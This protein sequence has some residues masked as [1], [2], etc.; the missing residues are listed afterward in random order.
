[1]PFN[2]PGGS[3]LQWHI[4]EVCLLGTTYQY[5]KMP[6]NAVQSVKLQYFE[7]VCTACV[8]TESG[9]NHRN[10]YINS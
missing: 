5:L 7:P 4:G 3:T 2:S 6:F 9:T 10:L 8:F 1:M